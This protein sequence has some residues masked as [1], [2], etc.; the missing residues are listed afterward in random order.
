MNLK[1]VVH[2][3]IVLAIL[4]TLLPALPA[5]ADGPYSI[6]GRVTDGEGTG[7]SGVTISM[8]WTAPTY[9]ISGRVTD[10][11]GAGI[12]GVVVSDGVGHTA[13][14]VGDGAYT[15]AGL[16]AGTYYLSASKEDHTF[17]PYLRA[18]IV[19]PG[20]TG[21]DFVGANTGQIRPINLT[22]SLYRDQ[23]STSD[24]DAY[25]DI[26]E[27]F[28]DAVYEMSN[29]VHR[30]CE[31]TIYLGDSKADADVL[32][33]PEQWPQA[34]V[35]AYGRAGHIIMGDVFPFKTPYNA[36]EAANRQGAGYALAHEWGHYFYGLYDEY[37][38]TKE[39]CTESNLRKGSPHSD[40]LP[41][42]DSIMN[43]SWNAAA[44]GGLAWLN[45]SVA[46]NYTAEHTDRTA[47]YRMYEASA[48]E[49]L[50]RP[51]SLDPRKSATT[52]RTTRRFWSDLVDVAPS[53][54]G[55]ASL[56]LPLGEVHAR[57][58]LTFAWMEA[59]DSGQMAQDT[60]SFAG[61]VESLAGRSVTYPE[62]VLLVAEVFNESRVDLITEVGVSAEVTAPDAITSSVTFTDDGQA[63]DAMANDGLYSALLA[64]DQ[65]G[66]YALQVTFDNH[67]GLAQYTSL[68]YSP[69]PGPDGE[70]PDTSLAPVGEAFEVLLESSVRVDGWASDDHGDSAAT[71]TALLTNNEDV[72][73]SIDHVG[74]EDWFV[75]T[76]T[77][78]CQLVLRV[79]DLA[80]GMQPVA[81][82]YDDGITS[83]DMPADTESYAFTV[84]DALAGQPIYVKV[85]HQDSEATMGLYFISVGPTLA[86]GG[87][88]ERSQGGV[89]LPIVLR[90]GDG[91]QAT[92]GAAAPGGASEA[93]TSGQPD[94]ADETPSPLA[95]QETLISAGATYS[96]T[97]DGSGNY[98]L[99][100]LP[101]GAYTLRPSQAGYSF[102]PVTRT[103][104][105]PT[106]ASGQDFVRSSAAPGDMV[107]V[108]AGSFQM[109]CDP[110]HNGGYSCY[111]DELPLHTVT[112]DAYTID[113]YEVTNA[114]YAQCV[115]AGA[116]A[117]PDSNASRTRS[118][119]Y[120]N[121]TYADYPVIYVSW[122]DAEDYCA[123]AG[124]RLPTEAEW[125]K[126]AR[127]AA[128]TRAYP[129]GDGSPSCALA[130]SYN[131]GTSSYCVGDTTA[132]GSYPAG[133]S[134]YG[135]MDMTGNVWEWVNDWYGS[136]YYS[137]SPASNPPGPATGTYKVF[138]GGSFYNS[139]G[140]V[141]VAYRGGSYPTGSSDGG[142]FRCAAS[143]PG[144]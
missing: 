136:S 91:G 79:T 12:A 77:T 46:K 10:S 72:A 61:Q 109:G 51:T 139:W 121:A 122:Y 144:P 42:Q 125:E 1:A 130:N 135:A 41:V 85:F 132:V 88:P 58:C 112:L 127:G 119:Y 65:G 102:T 54:R 86:S 19:P 110:A 118:S 123:W 84:L 129:W 36:L 34:S 8:V 107:L 95:G 104:T 67:S 55:D 89:Y 25:M 49:T 39:D 32:W 81:V 76:P 14:T 26:L 62:P 101:A 80:L 74:D 83:L 87:E 137:T 98:S 4:V 50:A 22:L 117:A 3:L 82:V 33:E 100:G 106:S 21:Q 7:V 57:A 93:G 69:S 45:F 97:T 30:I 2:K 31:M 28:A 115:A 142:G 43:R 5:A 73:G 128:D 92:P 56:Q 47:Q 108:P 59:P 13:T 70:M 27:Y 60:S 120:N 90:N 16:T 18:A 11:T 111:S 15:L 71:A 124:K 35:S 20:A 140:N 52:A 29:G 133:V 48:W 103:V 114:Q 138:R 37:K 78:T 44:G 68:A 9:S 134:P 75:I 64:Y 126:A 63:P 94:I 99:S 105:L 24:K 53:A 6:S 66:D 141:R 17:S 116:C 96:A 23:V 131:S 40:D 113:K 38:C 143:S